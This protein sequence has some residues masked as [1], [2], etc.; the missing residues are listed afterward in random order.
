MF[1]MRILFASIGGYA[2]ETCQTNKQQQKITYEMNAI[3]ATHSRIHTH[4]ETRAMGAA[5]PKCMATI[6]WTIKNY[7]RK[8]LTHTYI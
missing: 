1:Y 5:G 8:S 4:W 7:N 6:L 2:V 3:K